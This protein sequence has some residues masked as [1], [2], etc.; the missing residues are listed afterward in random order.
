LD[1]FPGDLS[2]CLHLLIGFDVVE[3]GH[4]G[5]LTAMG[6]VWALVVV[7]GDPAPDGNFGL[8][9]W[10]PSVQIT[11]SYFRDRQRR[12]MKMLSRQRPLPSI[13]IRVPTRFKRSV[14]TKD[15]NWLP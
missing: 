3:V 11:H 5:R 7:E 13:E 6:S 4:G 15:V 8:R 9:P 12:S 2:Y 1:G 14:Q 10:L